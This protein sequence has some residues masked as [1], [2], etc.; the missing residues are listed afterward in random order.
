MHATPGLLILGWWGLT[1]LVGI[2]SM[3]IDKML[4][5]GGHR[6]I[7]ERTL[8][9]VALAG[10]FA[11]IAVGGLAFHHKTSKPLFWVPVAI[12]I[13][14]WVGLLWAVGSS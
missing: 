9:L 7:S 6:R 13:V 2:V 5:K 12:A 1:S 10:G 14:V 3:G 8:W 11:G 4:A